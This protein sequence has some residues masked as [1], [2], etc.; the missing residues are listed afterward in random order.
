VHGALYGTPREEV[1][2]LLGEGRDVLLEID[3]QGARQVKELVPGSVTIFLEPPS[4]EALERRLRDRGTED[5]PT[6]RLR[7]ETARHELE[8]AGMFDHR[9]VNED[10]ERAVEQV[11]RILEQR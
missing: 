6:M 7:L 4:W 11:D 1:E 2:R 5:E 3:V 9:V 8:N 10:L